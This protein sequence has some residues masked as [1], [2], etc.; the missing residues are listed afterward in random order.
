MGMDLPADHLTAQAILI[1]VGCQGDGYAYELHPR[2]RRLL[3]EHFPQVARVPSL[4]VGA[5]DTARPRQDDRILRH[6]AILLT[7]LTPEQ[8]AELG[9]V[10]F[11]A[12]VAEVCYALEE[13]AGQPS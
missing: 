10:V 5:D 9:G 11:Y 7:G 12:P 1:H 3:E 6:V 13:P 8:A 4:F 2:S